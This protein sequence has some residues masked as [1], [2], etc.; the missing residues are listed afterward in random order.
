M[1]TTVEQAAI[2]LG[3]YTL[4]IILFLKFCFQKKNGEY[5]RSSGIRIL[6]LFVGV[7]SLIPMLMFIAC[8]Y[9]IISELF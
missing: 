5:C 1:F 4:I 9:D 6:G 2:P 3:I 7:I 8:I